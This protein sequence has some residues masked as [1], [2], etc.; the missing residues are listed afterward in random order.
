MPW[1]NETFVAFV[2]IA[3]AVDIPGILPVYLGLVEEYRSEQ[4]RE[5]I[6]A[7]LITSS[8]TG[9]AFLFLGRAILGILG[10]TLIDFQFGGGLILIIMGVHELLGGE[11]RVRRPSAEVGMVPLGVPLIIGP[12][13]ISIMVI[14]IDQHG[15]GPTLTAFLANIALVG[16]VFNYSSGVIRIFGGNG[17]RVVSKIIMLFLVA[18]GMKMIRTGIIATFMR[19]E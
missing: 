1:L 19:H 13:V 18:L 11:M 14:S 7:G 12:A 4:R 6:R 9:L 15:L 2:K 16:F 3:V 5:V 10:I 17:L 8:F